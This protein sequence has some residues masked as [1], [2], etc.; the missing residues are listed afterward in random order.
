[1][2]RRP[3]WKNLV[4]QS[5]ALRRGQ[6]SATS[7]SVAACELINCILFRSLSEQSSREVF[8]PSFSLMLHID[9]LCTSMT[10][11]Y[12]RRMRLRILP[13]QPRT[14]TDLKLLV[15]K[16]RLSRHIDNASPSISAVHSMQLLCSVARNTSWLS[17]LSSC[18]ELP[19]PARWIQI[20][21]TSKF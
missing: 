15:L 1:M 14:S 4:N 13:L 18:L 19:V 17:C 21:H 10:E 5:L 20:V 16:L 3:P 2:V 8:S 9:E 12:A 7:C 6:E 11:Q